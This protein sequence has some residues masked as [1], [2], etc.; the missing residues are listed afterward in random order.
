MS[1]I[2]GVWS[3]GSGYLA[4]STSVAEDI[5]GGEEQ[6]STRF[7]VVFTVGIGCGA[8]FCNKLLGGRVSGK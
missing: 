1:G 2:G 8:T 7:R 5:V 3:R 6:V 4:Q